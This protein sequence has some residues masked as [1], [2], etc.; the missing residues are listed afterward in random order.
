V[1]SGSHISVTLSL[2]AQQA[3]VKVEK[4]SSSN[5]SRSRENILGHDIVSGWSKC[6]EPMF[7]YCYYHEMQP[8]PTAEDIAHWAQ[9]IWDWRFG[10]EHPL[11]IANSPQ[12]L[13]LVSDFIDNV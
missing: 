4:P 3:V 5:K 11:T 13:Q 9:P 2:I 7:V 8:W 1:V 10:D 6:I 12:H